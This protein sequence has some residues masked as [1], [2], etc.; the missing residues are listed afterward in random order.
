MTAQVG[1]RHARLVVKTLHGGLGD[2]LHEGDIALLVLGE[3]HHVV[4]L[5]LAVARE[6][7][8]G[9]EIHLAAE[10]GLD[11]QRRLELVD[12]ALLVLGEEHHVV[13]LGLAVAREGL[14]GGE[15]HLAAEDGLDDQ[16]RLELVD[17]A[18]LIPHSEVLHVLLVTA[19]IGLLIGALELIATTLLQEGLVVAPD[20]VLGR[21][22]VHGVAGQAELGNAVHVAVVGDGHGRH[23][24]LDSARHHVL[25]ARR[26][27][28]HGV[29]GV[30][31]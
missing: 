5:G 29:D 13:E 8:I 27:V 19:R 22:M 1:Q 15:I 26:A 7:L 30:G 21:T 28:Q 11:D 17:I 12:I 6:G 23:A 4:E 14:I 24:Q 31:V 9:G 3:E 16:R 18:L 20:L 25:D 2:R 10:D